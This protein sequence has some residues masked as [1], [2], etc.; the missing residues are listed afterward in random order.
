[1]PAGGGLG[2]DD[3]DGRT[4]STARPRP[5]RTSAPAPPPLSVL[6][7][8]PSPPVA[9]AA[10]A[11]I[12]ASSARGPYKGNVV[13]GGGGGGG[14]LISWS[15]ANMSEMKTALSHLYNQARHHS[16]PCFVIIY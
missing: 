5:G 8:P 16:I 7:M 6:A 11:D 2:G 1:M 3:P 12:G 15:G 4:T 13:G 10:A 14:D 9:P